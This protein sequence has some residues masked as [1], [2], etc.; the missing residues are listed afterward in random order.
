MNSIRHQLFVGLVSLLTVVGVAAGLGM[1]A[2]A[3]Q[4]AN[5][6]FDYHL[7]QLAFALRDHAA[8]AVEV[9]GSEDDDVEQDIVIQIWDEDGTTCII[10]PG[11]SLP[12]AAPGW[13]SHRPSRQGVAK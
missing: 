3:F 9:S 13:S 10:R 7:K 8:T 2:T 6:V 1:Y 4:A 12:R 11:P 5:T